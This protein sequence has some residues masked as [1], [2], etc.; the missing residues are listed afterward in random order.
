MSED[1][2]N[3]DNNKLIEA[4]KPLF[5]GFVV[6]AAFVFSKS[7]GFSGAVLGV[8]V[9]AALTFVS[10]SLTDILDEEYRKFAEVI[11]VSTLLFAVLAASY[12]SFAL[13]VGF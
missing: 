7:P 8:S 5:Y 6:L 13:S 12:I 3:V 9:M 4:S 11:A 10:A 1:W 2:L